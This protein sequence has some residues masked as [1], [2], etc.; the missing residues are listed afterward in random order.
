MEIEAPAKINLYLNIL[1]RRD[2][3]Y[4]EIDTLFEKISIRDTLV[5]EL[6][7]KKTNIVCRNPDVPTGPD[8]LL[9]R[10]I[11]LF[12]EKTGKVY[13]FTVELEKRIPVSAGMG[14]GSSDAAALLKAINGL[15]G[16]PLKMGDLLE[17]SR[18]LGADVPFFLHEAS[19][20]YGRERGDV[21][22]EVETSVDLWHIIVHPPFKVS[23]KSI[24][25]RVS[26]FGLTKN[27]G[28]DKMFTAFLRENNV[29]GI[30]GNLHNDLQ[31]ITLEEFPA[32]ME[33]LSELKKAG[34]K[35]TLMAG[36]GPA[37]FGIFDK[38][39][40]IQAKLGLD[41][42]FPAKENW[43]VFVAGT[44]RAPGGSPGAKAAHMTQ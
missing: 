24:Y 5:A 40:A 34:A 43:E 37:V 11:Y 29:D 41:A 8:S 26:R 13:N 42:I 3:G 44:Y 19:F 7:G 16:F 33:V 1:G 27:S 14:G 10:V 36:S 6:A 17:I 15:T 23:T 9:S 4:H 18:E 2:D 28:V 35:G 30:A 32:L 31:R 21:I 12:N 20:A 39:D 22:R 38:K 25:G